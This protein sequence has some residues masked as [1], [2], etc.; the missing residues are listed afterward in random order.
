MCPLSI[1]PR[2][3]VC[4]S[5]R[6]Y[7]QR[8]SVYTC[9]YIHTLYMLGCMDAWI[10]GWM[11]GWAYVLARKHAH[12]HVHVYVC[13]WMLKVCVDV[14]MFEAHRLQSYAS[15]VSATKHLQSFPQ[16]DSPRFI[17]GPDSS[18]SLG[19]Y[20]FVFVDGV[21]YIYIYLSLSRSHTDSGLYTY[22]Y[23]HIHIIY[24]STNHASPYIRF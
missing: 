23:I 12:V 21:I 19:I 8:T 1:Y 17:Q 20:I 5:V 2:M 15:A 11:D 22:I 6:L 3:C 13:L 18:K 14:P 16:C 7:V 24:L 9:I 10:N 4:V